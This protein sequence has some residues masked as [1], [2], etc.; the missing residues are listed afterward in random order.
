M[1]AELAI[2]ARGKTPAA[3][4]ADKNKDMKPA[5]AKAKAVRSASSKAVP[6]SPTTSSTTPC[7]RVSQL[8]AITGVSWG[9][10]EDSPERLRQDVDAARQKHD[11]EESV[12]AL[13]EARKLMQQGSYDEAER[14]AYRAR[15]CTAPIASGT[16]ATVRAR[17]W[18]TWSWP[19]SKARLPPRSRPPS[20]P[21]SPS[22][23]RLPPRR[24]RQRRPTPPGEEPAGRLPDAGRDGPQAGRACRRR[25][26]TRRRPRR[27]SCW[28]RS[29]SWSSKTSCWRPVRR[30]RRP[31]S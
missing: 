22:R 4:A 1:Q 6:N 23:S 27:C 30:R 8:R 20:P 10:F 17:C 29:A 15:S 7:R 24:R 9:L 18:P 19:A 14:A 31:P 26:R 3:V 13:A 21:R 25:S 28:P 11:Q 16:S 5:D 2:E 12:K